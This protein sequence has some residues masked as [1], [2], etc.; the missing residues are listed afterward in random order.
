[1][2]PW[3]VLL[4]CVRVDLGVMAMKNTPYSLKFQNWSFTIKWFNDICRTLV[5]VGVLALCRVAEGV[6]YSSSRLGCH[7]DQ[8]EKFIKEGFMK[9][10]KQKTKH[11]T[12]IFFD[13]EIA[14]E[15][16]W[17]YGIMR[18]LHDLGL[19]ISSVGEIN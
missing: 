14:F 3:Q 8:L 17:K 4:L 10:K 12:T 9:K 18:D 19:K 2:K 11:V 5:G 13:W 1:M 7:L 15:N 16:T 6:L